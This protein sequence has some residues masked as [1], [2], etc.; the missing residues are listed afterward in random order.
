[1]NLTRTFGPLVAGTLVAGITAFL[2]QLM[3]L[4]SVPPFRADFGLQ[5][6]GALI[7][8]WALLIALVFARWVALLVGFCGYLPRTS[9]SRPFR[10]LVRCL[11]A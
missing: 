8:I 1:M 4:N 7:L 10:G 9:W 2:V 5:M 3:Y 6:S 11:L